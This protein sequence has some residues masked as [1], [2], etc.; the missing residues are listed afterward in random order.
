M[1]ICDGKIIDGVITGIKKSVKNPTI[2]V[3][4]NSWN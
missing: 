3:R 2:L 1:I 4:Q